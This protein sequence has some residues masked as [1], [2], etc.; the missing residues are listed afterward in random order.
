[1]TDDEVALFFW[2]C[3][4]AVKE[5]DE[6][7]RCEVLQ[8]GDVVNLE[9]CLFSFLRIDRHGG[10]DF[11]LIIDSEK[12]GAIKAVMFA[13]NSG[14]HGHGLLTAVFLIGRN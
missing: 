3:Q 5:D 12:D 1:M 2:Q 11:S 8:A 4:K 14:H 7:G 9:I 10:I 6:I 13:E